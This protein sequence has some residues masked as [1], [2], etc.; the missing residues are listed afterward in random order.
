MKP[1]ANANII[2]NG[3]LEI[4]LDNAIPISCN[5]PTKLSIL[6]QHIE[7]P[8]TLKDYIRENIDFYTHNIDLLQLLLQIYLPLS[9]LM[10][11][12]THNDLHAENILLYQIPNNQYIEMTYQLEDL[13]EI[14]FYTKYIVRFIDYGRCYFYNKNT[15]FSSKDYY[16]IIQ[17]NPDCMKNFNMERMMGYNWFIDDFTEDNYFISSLKSNPSKD[18]W[19]A[20]LLLKYLSPD[21]KSPIKEDLINVLKNIQLKSEYGGMNI[22]EINTICNDPINN[23][24]S[25]SVKMLADNLIKIYK[26]HTHIFRE[27]QLLYFQ[28]TFMLGKMRIYL[29]T[30]KDIDF[31]LTSTQYRQSVPLSAKHTTKRKRTTNKIP[32][33]K[34]NKTN[35]DYIYNK[36]ERFVV[37][38]INILILANY[39][40]FYVILLFYMLNILYT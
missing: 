15:N 14:T 12:F 35:P 8:I 25:C 3:L 2:R 11:E 1:T 27:Q 4:E 6:I 18:V 34:K 24:Y 9:K 33:S 30:D 36:F 38:N 40:L 26:K 13:T 19:A 29:D 22:T 31:Q 23:L 21:K 7:N 39:F 28:D 20:Y 5:D 32:K 37:R 10:N 16:N 17:N